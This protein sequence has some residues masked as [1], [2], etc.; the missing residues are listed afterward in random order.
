MGAESEGGSGTPAA[1]RGR[2]ML[3]D[4]GAAAGWSEG[5]GAG[6]GLLSSLGGGAGFGS[7][8]LRRHVLR[9]RV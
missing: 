1:S 9:F 8:N 2:D 6:H 3:N 7:R 4:R 5:C